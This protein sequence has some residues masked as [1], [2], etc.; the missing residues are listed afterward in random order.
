MDSPTSIS[1]CVAQTGTIGGVG[2]TAQILVEVGVELGWA[3]GGSGGWMWWKT[4]CAHM[5]FSKPNDILKL[6]WVICL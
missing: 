2:K 5:K 3:I 1:I 4:L 6:K